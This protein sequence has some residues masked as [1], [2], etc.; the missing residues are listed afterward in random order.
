MFASRRNCSKRFFG[1]KVIRL[2]LVVEIRLFYDRKQPTSNR[3]KDEF[4]TSNVLKISWIYWI[5]RHWPSVFDFQLYHDFG[6][7]CSRK[8]SVALPAL[9]GRRFDLKSLLWI[10]RLKFFLKIVNVKGFI[11]SKYRSFSYGRFYWR[12]R[13]KRIDHRCHDRSSCLRTACIELLR[14]WM[15]VSV[16]WFRKHRRWRRRKNVRRKL[17]LVR[18]EM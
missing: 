8:S 1:K 4:E 5:S 7:V 11:Q 16:V 10:F 12:K 6:P 14:M 2:Y 18:N 9:F 15:F 3:S 17:R 13:R